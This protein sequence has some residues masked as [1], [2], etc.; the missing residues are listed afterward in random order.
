MRNAEQYLAS[1]EIARSS[2]STARREAQ[3]SFWVSVTKRS[4][5]CLQHSHMYMAV[6]LLKALLIP[7][8]LTFNQAPTFHLL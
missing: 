8:P 3:L 7:V 1:A 6:K 2:A 4:R 5:L